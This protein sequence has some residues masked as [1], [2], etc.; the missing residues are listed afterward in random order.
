[1]SKTKE[2][3]FNQGVEDA[4]AGKTLPVVEGKQS[5]QQAAYAAGFNS[6]PVAAAPVIKAASTERTVT[7]YTNG[8]YAEMERLRAKHGS[9]LTRSR[10]AVRKRYLKLQRH[11]DFA[12][13]G[14]SSLKGYSSLMQMF[15]AA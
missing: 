5:W 14:R 8:L 2:Q 13:H 4:K 7:A 1:M 3:F 9:I 10:P 15:G 11:L 6:V 12:N